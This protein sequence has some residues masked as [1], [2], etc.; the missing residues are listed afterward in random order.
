[1]LKCTHAGIVVYGNES[2]RL[3]HGEPTDLSRNRPQLQIPQTSVAHRPQA[4]IPQTSV[5][6]DV[7]ADPTDLRGQSPLSNMAGSGSV[8]KYTG[9]DFRNYLG[10]IFHIRSDSK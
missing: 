6:T 10:S 3:C 7:T 2:Q 5:A 8:Q 9:P 4:Q 1:M